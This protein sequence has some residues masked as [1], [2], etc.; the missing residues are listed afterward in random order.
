MLFLILLRLIVRLVI[1]ILYYYYEQRNRDCTITDR[2]R[3]L[4]TPIKGYHLAHVRRGQ[5]QKSAESH[6]V[7]G[8][9]QFHLRNQ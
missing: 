7:H 5:R 8:G 4:Q 2:Q 6:K 3:P 9:L 1:I